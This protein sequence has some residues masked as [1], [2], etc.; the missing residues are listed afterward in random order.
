MGV[1]E[2]HLMGESPT[3]PSP[4]VSITIIEARQLVGLNMDPVVCVEVGEEK[5][6]TSMKES[7]NCPYYNEV[8]LSDPPFL[9][10]QT[11]HR[12]AVFLPQKIYSPA[13]TPA[14]SLSV[15]RLR[16]PRAPRRHV[17]QDHQA[18]RE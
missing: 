10:W 17:R 1:P 16:F 9:S 14:L 5:K 12:N 18:V 13:L 15:L 3:N 8:G 7:T 2:Q 4:Q 11:E 6:Y